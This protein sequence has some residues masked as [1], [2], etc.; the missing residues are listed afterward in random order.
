[1]ARLREPRATAALF[2]TARF[3]QN[4]ENCYRAMMAG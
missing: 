3:V 4:L 2:D 1:M